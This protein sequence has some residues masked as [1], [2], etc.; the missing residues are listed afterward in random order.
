LESLRVFEASARH[1]NFTRAAAELGVTPAAVSLRIRTLETELGQSL[2]RRNGPHIALTDG[3]ARFAARLA[4]AMAI[5]RSAVAECR[6]GAT[7]LQLTTTPTFADWLASHLPRY[8]ALS[9]AARLRLDI[10]PDLRPPG[11]FDVAIR[12]G[13]GNWPGMREIYL[14][15]VLGTP[16]LSPSLAAQFPLERP[17]DLQHVPL[18]PDVN[19]RAWF[20][21]AG[22]PD[23]QLKVTSAVMPTQAMTAAAA[24]GGTGV[25][26]LSP[27]VF[28]DQLAE[29]K[30]VRPFAQ[31]FVGPESYYALRPEN[32]GRRD[33]DDFVRWLASEL[34]SRSEALGESWQIPVP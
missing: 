33:A 29:G 8:Q 15:P 14:L 13:Y 31:V 5:V 12:S 18:L 7:R 22:I 11:T 17:A 20:R 10:S 16:M 25:A 1:G 6:E 30:L 3:G 9:G 26:L 21:Q 4:D 2:F 23:P 32:D 24:I 34:S 28:A 27:V 19:W